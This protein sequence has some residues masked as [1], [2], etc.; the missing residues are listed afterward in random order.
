MWSWVYTWVSPYAAFT[1]F[2]RASIYKQPRHSWSTLHKYI[3]FG[4]ICRVDGKQP[5]GATIKP[6]YRGCILNVTC[7]HTFALS[8]HAAAG[9]REVGAVAPEASEVCRAITVTFCSHYHQDFIG[10]Q[11][12]STLLPFRMWPQHTRGDREGSLQLPPMAAGCRETGAVLGTSSVS[13]GCHLLHVLSITA[14]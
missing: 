13:G 3:A 10:L 2:C 1:C 5:N 8:H 9:M 4:A 12:N 7:P 6:W 14:W 11:V